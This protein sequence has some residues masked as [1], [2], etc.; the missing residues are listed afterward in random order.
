MSPN[1][2]SARLFLDS[3]FGQ[4]MRFDLQVNQTYT[5]CQATGAAWYNGSGELLGWGDIAIEDL[6]RI[7]VGLRPGET[8]LILPKD[9]RRASDP[10]MGLRYLAEHVRFVVTAE[11]VYMRNEFGHPS[12][13]PPTLAR[14]E[15]R[16]DR[17]LRITAGV[18]YIDNEQLLELLVE[19]VAA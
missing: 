18:R 9:A 17:K 1:P 14:D 8:F 2:L 6:E 5:Y 16:L 19:L 12:N 13:Q 4:H 15:T 3:N 7:H 11:A 10:D